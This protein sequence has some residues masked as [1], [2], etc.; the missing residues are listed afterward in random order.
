MKA[1]AA[2]WR[3]R[4]WLMA[5]AVAGVVVGGCDGVSLAGPTR[6]S[7]LQV[8]GTVRD[9]VTGAPIANARVSVAVTEGYVP[10]ELTSVRT[11]AEGRYTL[12]YRLRNVATDREFGDTCTIWHKDRS[13]SVWIRAVADGYWL[14]ADSSE[15]G[16][17]ALRCVDAVQ[18]IDLK[19]RSAP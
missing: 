14:W 11:D 10:T 15:D 4:R 9:A 19:L 12:T 2:R 18:I 7:N 3:N 13:T 6:E 5:V 17:P 8:Q 1:I 16:A